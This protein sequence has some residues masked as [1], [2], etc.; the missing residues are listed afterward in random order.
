MRSWCL[1]LRL[2]SV[3][4][5]AVWKEPGRFSETSRHPLRRDPTGK[6]SSRECS[7]RHAHLAV[8]IARTAPDQEEAG[9]NARRSGQPAM[10]LTNQCVESNGAGS[11]R[12]NRSQPRARHLDSTGARQEPHFGRGPDHEIAFQSRLIALPHRDPVDRF[13]VATALVNGFTLA[14]ADDHLLHIRRIR[15]IP[16][17]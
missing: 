13:V 12:K 6:S 11:V 2:A 10:A 4:S 15:T 3:R 7:P 5:S 16:N 1:L 9:I 8:G 14:T 17:R